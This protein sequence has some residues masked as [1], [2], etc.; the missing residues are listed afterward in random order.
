MNKYYT[1]RGDEGQT[2]Q[3]GKNR[4][5]KSHQRIRA[6]GA[7]DEASAAL[8][9]ARAQIDLPEFQALIKAIQTDLYRIMTQVSLEEPNPDQ[10]PDL[11]PARLD[12]LEDKIS[13]YGDP[14]EKPKGFILPGENLPSAALGLARTIIRRAE[15]ETVALHQEGLLFSS[16]ALPYLNRLSSLCFVLELMTAANPPR[17]GD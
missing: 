4:L 17:E 5:S 8:G 14:L 15:R 6:L 1:S 10:F 2:D 16:N 3:L 9:L 11:E 12:W 13:R 7:I